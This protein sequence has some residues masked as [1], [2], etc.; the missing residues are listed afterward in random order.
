[1]AAWR[2]F[3]VKLLVCAI[4]ASFRP[5][6]ADVPQGPQAR[7]AATLGRGVD[8]NIST[9]RGNI[10]IVGFGQAKAR[11]GAIFF[12]HGDPEWHR[13]GDYAQSVRDEEA[14]VFANHLEWLR[15]VASKGRYAT[16]FVARTGMFGSDGETAEFRREDA[17]LAIGHAIDKVIARDGIT[18][19]AIVGHSGGAAVALYHAIA[20]PNV[21][22]RCYALASGVYNIGA[23]AEFMRLQKLGG[24]DVASIDRTALAPI[25]FTPM[26]VEIATKL[27]YF[28]PLFRIK[29]MPTDASRQ[30]I[31]VSDRRDTTTPFFASADLVDRMKA[32]GHRALLVEGQAK[33]PGYHYT[34][35]AALAAAGACLDAGGR[36]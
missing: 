12:I 31:A 15:T 18:A 26:P 2:R 9:E 30:I 1:M 34:Y 13:I 7:L 11:Q 21:A 24:T 3:E 14:R 35:D 6:H 23:M 8:R 20:L 36:R 33:P 25:A 29:D 22:A 17:Y 28:E 32:L 19:A 5:V 16:Y 4:L 10:R 27:K